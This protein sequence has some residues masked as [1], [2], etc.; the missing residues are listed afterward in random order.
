[1][2]VAGVPSG[3]INNDGFLDLFVVNYKTNS[4]LYKNNG[5]GTFTDVTVSTGLSNIKDIVCSWADY[6]NNDCLFKNSSLD[7]SF[8]DVTTHAG[9]LP[10][11]GR[12]ISW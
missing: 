6:N 9:F 8:S 12:C 2:V 4:I 5:Y 1:M 7:H 10:K 11:R 3:S